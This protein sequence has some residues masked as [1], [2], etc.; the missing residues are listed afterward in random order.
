MN[1]HEPI[2]CRCWL[3]IARINYF[4]AMQFLLEFFFMIFA[5]SFVEKKLFFFFEK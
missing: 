5:V 2:G 3:M 4:I 1:V